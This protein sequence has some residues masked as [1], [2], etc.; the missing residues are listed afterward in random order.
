M[1]RRLP[2]R[3]LTTGGVAA[4][5]AVGAL[6]AEPA[7]A[8]G[9]DAGAVALGPSAGTA[10][11]ERDVPEHEAEHEAEAASSTQRSGLEYRFMAESW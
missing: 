3:T 8:V 9:G 4:A 7:A 10:G 11:P 1:V 6:G 2:G 5:G